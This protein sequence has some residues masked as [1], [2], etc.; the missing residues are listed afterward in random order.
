MKTQIN[1]LRIL[2]VVLGMSLLPLA[3]CRKKEETPAVV[4]P[5]EDD[6]QT[7][8]LD[9]NTAENF[10]ADIESIGSEVSENNALVSYKGTADQGVTGEYGLAASPCA[11]ISGLGT[12]TFTVDFGT[13]GCVGLDGRTRT[14]K[15]IFDFTVSTPSTSIYYRNP[16]FS[17]SV[18]SQNY[19][20]DGYTVNV[21]SKNVTNTTPS[22]IPTG[23]NPGTN[24]TWAITA[25]ITITKPSNAGT[26][27]WS[28]ART[29]EL[30]NTSDPNCYKG[31]N[32]PIDWSKA[33]VKLN[34]TAS[35]VN[36]KQENYT[37]S[38]TN[39][40]RDFNCSP[41]PQRPRRHPFIGGTLTYQPGNR[42]TRVINYGNGTNCDLNA[43]LT[44]GNKT[45]NITL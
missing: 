39:L 16:G 12:R 44:I 5:A 4:T 37:S 8:A 9:N 20:V 33:I 15:L 19:V 24:L 41:D 26:I 28:C 21:I 17:M 29:K 7:S 18:S 13:S 32:T 43:T 34:G 1:L 38:A 42:L 35:G 22:S 23:T 31:Q 45:F 2:A 36:A 11:T 25:S 30:I 40:I 14:G 10:A 6:E 3:S 27:S